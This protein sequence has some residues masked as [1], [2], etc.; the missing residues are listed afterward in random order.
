MLSLTISA[1]IFEKDRAAS[2]A[3]TSLKVYELPCA[4][5]ASTRYPNSNVNVVNESKKF[6]TNLLC[7]QRH[8]LSDLPLRDDRSPIH[9]KGTKHTKVYSKQCTFSD[10]EKL[11]T[12]SPS[13]KNMSHRKDAKAAKIQSTQCI[14]SGSE[15]LHTASPS[16]RYWQ[17]GDPIV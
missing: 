14:F 2:S 17:F 8:A 15:K 6:S 3:R 11:H 16:A 5:T 1:S 7:V 9:R 10:G 12:A 4:T 13:A